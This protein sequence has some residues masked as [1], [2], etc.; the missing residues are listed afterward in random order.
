MNGSGRSAFQA[1][2]QG[3]TGKYADAERLFAK[4]PSFRN[5]S[6]CGWPVD[7]SRLVERLSR[8]PRDLLLSC[9]T[10]ALAAVDGRVVVARRLRNE[11]FPKPVYVIA[12]GKAA[13]AMTLGAR[14]VLG[15]A[16][17]DAFIVGKTPSIRCRGRSDRRP[18]VAI[19]AGSLLAGRELIAFVEPIPADADVLVLLSGGLDAG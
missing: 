19:N 12:I 6:A 10:A 2:G 4:L 8:S 18:S 14:D 5:P 7:R 17:V 11:R 15:E 9:Y 16:I 3:G 1:L 13:E